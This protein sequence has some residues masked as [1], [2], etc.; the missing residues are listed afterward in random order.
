MRGV[1]VRAVQSRLT[2]FMCPPR[3][4]KS[5]EIIRATG[6]GRGNLAES[7]LVRL[8]GG[9]GAGRGVRHPLLDLSWSGK[10]TPQLESQTT[11][12]AVL[13]SV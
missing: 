9:R 2:T 4:K 5:S 7:K 1:S 12:A 13:K 8:R 3:Q 6:G 10:V 11:A